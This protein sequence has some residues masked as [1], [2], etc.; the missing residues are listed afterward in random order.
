MSLTYGLQN[1][2]CSPCSSIFFFF[3]AQIKEQI[4]KEDLPFVFYVPCLDIAKTVKDYTVVI[5]HGE[6]LCNAPKEPL[7][8]FL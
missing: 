4:A 2:L 7:L 3:G 1:R 6:R 5:A 8:Y